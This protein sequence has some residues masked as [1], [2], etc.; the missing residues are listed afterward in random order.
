[1]ARVKRAL[2][3]TELQFKKFIEIPVASQFES[4]VG[5]P[6]LGASWIIWGGSG[7]GKTTFSMQ[8]AKELS[9]HHKVEYLSSEEGF[10][11]SMQEAVAHN[12]MH[13][14]RRGFFKL[15][16]PM[17]FQE[18][19]QR[20]SRP[21][22]AKIVFIDSVQYMFITKRE[23]FDFKNKHKDKLIIWISHAKGRE[24]KGDVADAIRYDSDVKIFV[25]GYLATA[26]SRLARGKITE[27]YIIWQEGYNNYYNVL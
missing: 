11:K 25:K 20:L 4:L 12:R 24:P 5:K 22:A 18:L 27:P 21:R 10:S 26:K 6:S 19:D 13:E 3:A 17:T 8:L 2:S 15:L 9:N 7:E 23:Y 1:M 14:C 16:E